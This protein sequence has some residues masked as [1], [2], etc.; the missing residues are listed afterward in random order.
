LQADAV[1]HGGHHPHVITSDSANVS[2]SRAGTS[3]N[4]STPYHDSYRNSQIV[5]LGDVFSNGFNRF[6]VETKAL[7]SSKSFPAEFEK[8]SLIGRLQTSSEV[9]F[10]EAVES[11]F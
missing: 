9:E 5:N 6:I 1:D 4:V 7:G 2:L 3:K 11:K 8:N 10:G